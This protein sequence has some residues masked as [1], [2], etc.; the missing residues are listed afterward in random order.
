MGADSLLETAADYC[1]RG[2][3]PVP[4]RYKSKAGVP[5][6][7]KFDPTP[8]ELE[9][10]FGNG[11]DNIG[12]LLGERS[13]D[14]V[15]VDLDCPMARSLAPSILPDTDCVFGRE[16]ARAPQADTYAQEEVVAEMRPLPLTSYGSLWSFP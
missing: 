16:S 12:I 2:W 10:Y 8:E 4:V 3:C 14:L 9:R 15:D 13:G 11:P 1:E 6:W 5:G 7:N